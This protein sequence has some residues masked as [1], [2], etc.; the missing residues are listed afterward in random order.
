MKTSIFSLAAAAALFAMPALAEHDDAYADQHQYQQGP[1]HQAQPPAGDPELHCDHAAMHPGH[2]HGDWRRHRRGR[3]ELRTTQRWVEGYYA[4]VFMPGHCVGQVVRVCS[5]GHYMQSW[6]PGR[7]VTEQSWVW[8]DH[9]RRF[10]WRA[11]G[12]R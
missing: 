8:V 12:R 7:Y 11:W 6:V 2:D 9:H 5:P 3:Y 10:G 4:Q 1:L